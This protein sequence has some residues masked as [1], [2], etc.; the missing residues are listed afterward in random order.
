[1]LLSGNLPSAVSG[2]PSP[3]P[4]ATQR[5]AAAR[6]ALRAAAQAASAGRVRTC[7]QPRCA[8]QRHSPVPCKTRGCLTSDSRVPPHSSSRLHMKRERAGGGGGPDA[9]GCCAAATC[10]HGWQPRGVCRGGAEG[11]APF[12]SPTIFLSSRATLGKVH[13]ATHNRAHPAVA[14]R[15]ATCMRIS[16]ACAAS[17]AAALACESRLTRRRVPCK[18]KRE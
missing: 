2:Q 10:P 11:S 17:G 3:L 8:P 18:V 6:R 9:R 14:W 12:Y 15:H 1:M 5:V 13:G 4:R 16:S 7:G